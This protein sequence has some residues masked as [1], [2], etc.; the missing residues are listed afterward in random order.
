MASVYDRDNFAGRV[1]YAAQCI[2]RG[3]IGTRALNSCFEMHDGDLVVSALVRRAQKNQQLHDAISKQW[4][5][6]F[7][8][9]WLD[10][11]AKYS[12]VPTRKLA[13]KAAEVRRLAAESFDRWM[14]E[15]RKTN[16]QAAAEGAKA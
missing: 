8:Q 15:R 1:N 7:P 4:R 14:E 2:M 12:D 6:A 9:Q 16:A 13:E 10:T 11:S 5:G 3:I